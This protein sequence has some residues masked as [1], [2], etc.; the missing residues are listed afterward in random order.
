[1]NRRL[2]LKMLAATSLNDFAISA[3]A[4]AEDS[5]LELDCTDLLARIRDGSLRA[6]Q[7]CA[8]FLEQYER[9]R[10][11]N[12]ITSIDKSNALSRARNVDRARNKGTRLPGLAGLPIL[13]KDNIDAVGLP[14]S[15]G[16]ASLRQNFPRRNAPVV[17]RL[18]Q[19][20][21][22][23][24]G[25]ANMH[26]LALGVTSSNPT[27]G[28]VRNPYNTNLIPGG[29]SG[30]SAAAIAARIVPAALGTDTG[31]S[32]RIPAAFCGTVGFRPSIYPRKLYSQQGVVPYTLDLDTVGPMGRSVADV[33]MLHAT[34]VGQLLVRT[35]SLKKA[36][37]GIPR[38]AY[39]D[40]LDPEVERV[41]Q[42]ALTRLR[43]QG[44]VLVEID[45]RGV[46]DAA[47]KIGFTLQSRMIA[48]L[49][50][51][52]RTQVPLVS[53]CD[54]EGQVTNSD[55]RAAIEKGGWAAPDPGLLNARGAGRDAIRAAYRAVFRQ[56]DIQAVVFP[57]VVL[58]PPPIRATSDNFNEMIEFNGR[59]VSEVLT[60]VRNTQPTA[61]LGAPALSL[62]AG[63]TSNGLP[64]GL[65]F[66]GLPGDDDALLALGLAAE[67]AIGRV[68]APPHVVRRP[69]ANS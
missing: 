46:K 66:D 69:T 24:L 62:P 18:L 68:P 50:N 36:R 5:I 21:A 27:F 9:Q 37:I 61:A 41:A 58:P 15:A 34:I 35:R 42:A 53:L 43:D 49:D 59:M 2:V 51:F 6:E 28:F 40:D 22:I 1:M 4:S 7:V 13:I 10:S 44:T 63:L 25:K 19:H 11:L 55:F 39:W 20:G 32:V 31:G 54:L 56:H 14:T 60:I 12:V 67:A 16:T 48:D 38:L 26:E 64:V 30:G 52:L 3:A 29:S 45:L 57:T 17:E 33:A 8:R 47:C 23:V 65:E